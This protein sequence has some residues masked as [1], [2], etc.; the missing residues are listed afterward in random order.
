MLKSNA[1]E[2]IANGEQVVLVVDTFTMRVLTSCLEMTDILACGY[3]GETTTQTPAA[4]HL[5]PRP[6]CPLRCLTLRSCG[7]V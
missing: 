3:A 1:L 2:Y 5:L 7:Q 6:A 4:A